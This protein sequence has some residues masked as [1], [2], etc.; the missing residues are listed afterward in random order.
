MRWAGEAAI[1]WAA[2]TALYLALA[3]QVST[4]ETVMGVSAGLLLAIL[5]LLL[6]DRAEPALRVS[7]PWHRLLPRAGWSI[8]RDLVRVAG[9]LARAI[10]LGRAGSIARQPFAAKHDGAR[11]AGRNAL[12]IL[13]ASLAP[14]GYVL[15]RRR[16]SLLLHRLAKAP[17]APK[18][19][20]AI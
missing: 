18:R 9:A 20:W 2:L 1:R 10:V 15:E 4:A 12:A 13:L 11:A 3:G 17:A 6:R 7:A 8:L 5:S 16:D 19:D 14:N